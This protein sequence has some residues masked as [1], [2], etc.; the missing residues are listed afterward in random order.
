EPAI[1]DVVQAAVA[2]IVVIVAVTAEA[3]LLE[4][5]LAQPVER[6]HRIAHRA[7]PRPPGQD[8]ETLPLA[9][10][11]KIGMFDPRDL[12]RPQPPIDLRL[13][14]TH[15]VAERSKRVVDQHP[16]AWWMPA[17]VSAARCSSSASSSVRR[18]AWRAA[19]CA[20][21]LVASRSSSSR[22]SWW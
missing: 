5:E 18:A 9:R 21:A 12:E 17:V 3:F 1:E 6:L 13:G 2:G 15:G 16:G 19:A 7:G 11:H 22:P 4:E 20:S 10:R 14:A 8:V